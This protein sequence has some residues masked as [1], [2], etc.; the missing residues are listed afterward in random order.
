MGR[1]TRKDVAAAAGVSETIVSYVLNANRYVDRDKKER[2]LK[3]VRDLGYIPSPVARALKRKESHHILFVVDDLLSE[4]FGSIIREM[5]RLVSGQGFLFSLVSDRGDKDFVNTISNWF[6]DGIIIGSSTIREEDIQ[7]IIDI[8][9]PTVILAMNDYPRFRG[10]YGLIYTGLKAGTLKAMRCLHER[11]R[12]R[13]AFVD[14]F[15]RNASP[16][17]ESGFRYL[18]YKEGLE[19]KEE[20]I[21]DCLA[22]SEALKRKLMDAYREK[23]FDALF[24]RTD[25]VAAEAIIALTSEGI[26]IPSDVSVVGVDNSRVAMYTNP[27]LTSIAI[28]KADVANAVI[29]MF[30]AL[31]K[32]RENTV[33]IAQLE[34]DFIE[35]ESV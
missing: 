30:G 29:G 13:I 4:Y 17:N 6:F 3:A 15:S 12:K 23:H 20:I 10:R 8:G 19:G 35:R 14:S 27:R 22:T 2:V 26:R 21:I 25:R 1:V 5:E 31:R 34:T 28:R 11:G 7:R 16:V 18:G 32:G 33:L 24:C 9:M